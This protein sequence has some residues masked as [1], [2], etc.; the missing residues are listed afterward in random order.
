M[1][2]YYRHSEA[3]ASAIL[4]LL[5]NNSLSGVMFSAWF[6][7]LHVLQKAVARAILHLLCNNS[8]SGVMF[9]AW[10]SHLHVL[11]KAVAR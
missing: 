2:F 3:V 7:H 8:L 11:Q 10:F 6:S 1:M 9:S 4:H 5:C